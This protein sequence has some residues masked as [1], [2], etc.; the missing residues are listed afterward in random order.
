MKHPQD[1]RKASPNLMRLSRELAESST[2]T[3]LGIFCPHSHIVGLLS[4][5][6]ISL[7]PSALCQKRK[8]AADGGVSE[9]RLDA[10]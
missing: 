2:Q 6:G 5:L 7:S 4:A 1:E 10:K 3:P 8:F 9:Q